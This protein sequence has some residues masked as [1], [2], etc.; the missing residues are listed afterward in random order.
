MEHHPS[1]CSCRGPL[2]THT[3]CLSLSTCFLLSLIKV[4]R[5]GVFML[6]FRVFAFNTVF[7][8][9]NMKFEKKGT[10]SKKQY[11]YRQ[12]WWGL[13]R[14]FPEPL[15][16]YLPFYHIFKLWVWINI[17]AEGNENLVRWSLK[18]SRILFPN[19]FEL[20]YWLE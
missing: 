19:S 12:Q 14:C 5:V 7:S 15:P 1:P 18:R 10:K 20:Q 11:M 3:S 6:F 9:S 13:Q 17:L 16:S 4:S 2:S 8:I